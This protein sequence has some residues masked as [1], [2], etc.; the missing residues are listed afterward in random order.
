[1]QKNLQDAS[2]SSSRSFPINSEEALDKV[3]KSILYDCKSRE[4]D[5]DK[6]VI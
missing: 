3:R 1:M 5:E 2:C 4:Q 6:R